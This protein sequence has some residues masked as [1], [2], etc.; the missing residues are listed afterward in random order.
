MRSFG[1]TLAIAACFGSQV[2]ANDRVKSQPGYVERL[3]LHTCGN[4]RFNSDFTCCCRGRDGRRCVRPK[5][6]DVP[7]CDVPCRDVWCG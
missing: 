4:Q 3:A 6:F 2:A 5:K 1:L 7:G